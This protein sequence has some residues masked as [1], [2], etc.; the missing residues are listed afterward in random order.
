V[1]I[2][3][4]FVH[5]SRDEHRFFPVSLFRSPMF[6]AAICAGFIYNFGQAV[7]F[8]QVTNLWQYVNGLKTAQVALWQLP[9]RGP[10]S[11]PR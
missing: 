7:A 5:E 6:L 3:A 2:G 1:I 8:L 11:S 10:A 9:W 4:F